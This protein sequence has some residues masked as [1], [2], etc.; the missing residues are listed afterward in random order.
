M[1][2]SSTVLLDSLKVSGSFVVPTNIKRSPHH[3][4]ATLKCLISVNDM[5]QTSLPPCACL[6][7]I[8]HLHIKGEGLEL[9]QL[10]F[11]LALKR[12]LLPQ[13]DQIDEEPLQHNSFL[14]KGDFFFNYVLN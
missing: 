4:S 6:S 8:L 2:E 3:L 5:F 11:F 13:S 7:K 10:K 9:S 1:E 14:N 12:F